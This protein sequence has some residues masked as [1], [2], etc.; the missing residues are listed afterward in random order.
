M[1]AS[2]AGNLAKTKVKA[3]FQSDE[4]AA[5]ARSEANRESGNLIAQT[6]G[7]LKGA[8]M[9]VGQMASIAHDVLPK[10]LSDALGKLQREAPPMDFEVIA[11][12]IER[13]LGSPPEVLFSKFDPEPFAAAS[14]GQVHRATTDD[15]REV[16][17]KVQ[18]PGVD[19]AVDSDL[20][21]LKIALRASG[22][23]NIGREAL[24][25]SF[26][27]VRE[28]LHEELDYTNEAA[29]V[30]L[31]REFHVGRHDFMVLP[32]VVGERSSQRV[33]TLT[34]EPGD[35]LTELDDKGYTQAE[36]DTL[37]RNLFHMMCSQVFEFG[38]IH[39][40]PNPGNFAF[41]RDGTIV[42]YDFGC[43]KR[44]ELDIIV[45]YKDLIEQ[46]IAEDWDAVDDAL[47][48]LEVR[49]P[50]GPRPDDS[51]Y[52]G[53]RDTFAD[54]FLDV[55]IFDYGRSTVHD[56]VV[57]LVPGSIKRMASFQPATELI[58]LDRTVVGHY[59]NMRILRS[60]VPSYTL[61]KG[62]LDAFPGEFTARPA[63]A[64]A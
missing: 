11:E 60:R 40:D 45:A 13:E 27:E 53:W 42:L 9:K 2:V 14:I 32:E 6:L 34:Y 44:L 62:Y 55:A 52:K 10:E 38:I 17:V 39:A 28:R 4:D 64:P 15:G 49:R 7:E 47:M 43:A 12:Q 31:F 30:R 63:D 61:L 21:Q 41:R 46:G 29:N 24:N 25:A 35:S 1:T 20:A 59:G 57:K 56:E 18:Y 58:F 19:G 50:S 26:K 51:F 16:V 3:L 23:V 37:G 36:R 48:R 22:I 33:L 54:P 8:V 5:A